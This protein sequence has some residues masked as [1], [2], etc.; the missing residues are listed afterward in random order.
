MFREDDVGGLLVDALECS[1][2]FIV[3][4]AVRDVRLD[5]RGS[6]VAS[7]CLVQ[8]RQVRSPGSS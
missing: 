8:G 3:R 1:K 2:C 4:R 6:Q 5:G 7:V